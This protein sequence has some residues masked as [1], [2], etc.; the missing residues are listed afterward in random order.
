MGNNYTGLH[1][2][3]GAVRA[4]APRSSLVVG[5]WLLANQVSAPL[6]RSK[7]DLASNRL[8]WE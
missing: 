3:L 4:T 8:R 7:P 2:G 1:G 6:V 5:A